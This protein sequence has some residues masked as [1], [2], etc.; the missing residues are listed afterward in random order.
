MKKIFIVT[1]LAALLLGGCTNVGASYL[2][3]SSAVDQV[4]GT[5]KAEIVDAKNGIDYDVSTGKATITKPGVYEIFY[6]PQSGK[7]GGCSHYWLAVNGTD[8]TNSNIEVC[9]PVNMTVASPVN[10]IVD[11]KKGDT[12]GFRMSG[13]LGADATRIDGE[14]LI[15]SAIISV[16]KL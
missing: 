14:P 3:L 11:L 8:L 10:A 13:D 7:L 16:K 1:L 9:L 5:F 15:P 4:D 12:L 2:Q 6:T